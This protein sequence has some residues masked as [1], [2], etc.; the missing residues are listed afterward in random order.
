[1][2][3]G[4]RRIDFAKDLQ[5][6]LHDHKGALAVYQ[7]DDVPDRHYKLIMDICQEVGFKHY[8]LANNKPE[9]QVQHHGGL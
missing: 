2:A 3:T 4:F 9:L 1:M 7:S 5:S 8:S 6:A